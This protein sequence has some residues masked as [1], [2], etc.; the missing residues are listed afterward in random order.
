MGG[1]INPG[2]SNAFAGQGIGD[3]SFSINNAGVANPTMDFAVQY[4]D[5]I[6]CSKA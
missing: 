2:I 5:V 4:I 3:V 6:L 1:R